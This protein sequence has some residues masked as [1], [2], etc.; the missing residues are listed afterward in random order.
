ME[1]NQHTLEQPMD[2]REIIRE[3]RKY[4]MN[5]NTLFSFAQ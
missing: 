2:Q 4:E 5:E 3:N 1:I